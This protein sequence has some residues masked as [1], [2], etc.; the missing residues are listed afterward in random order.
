MKQTLTDCGGVFR[1]VKR[2][3]D[4]EAEAFGFF[5]VD[6]YISG[7]RQVDWTHDSASGRA[8]LIGC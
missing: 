3:D 4:D 5:A 7:G 2:A 6:D 8:A 1:S